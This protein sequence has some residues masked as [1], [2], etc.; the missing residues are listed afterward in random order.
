MPGNVVIEIFGM[1]GDGDERKFWELL[2]NVK[3]S[4]LFLTFAMKT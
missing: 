2:G 1:L 4:C 3:K